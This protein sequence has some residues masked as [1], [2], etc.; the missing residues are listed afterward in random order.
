MK[1]PSV[2]GSFCISCHRRSQSE[3]N[4]NDNWLAMALGYCVRLLHWLAPW[5]I[6]PGESLRVAFEEWVD[7]RTW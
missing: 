1:Y 3:I 2:L 4:G 5:V 6:D 7:F